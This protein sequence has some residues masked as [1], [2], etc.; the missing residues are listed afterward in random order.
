MTQEIRLNA[1]NMNCGRHLSHGQ[2]GG[3]L[4]I[5][6]KGGATA[7]IKGATSPV[8]DDL[9]NDLRQVRS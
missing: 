4:S 1:F 7:S 8:L 3:L 5:R 2:I 9:L 6:V